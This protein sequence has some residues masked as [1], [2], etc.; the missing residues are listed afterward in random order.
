MLLKC[1]RRLLTPRVRAKVCLVAAGEQLGHV[2]EVAQPIVDRRRGE[3]EERLRPHRVV[4]QVEEPVVAR[5]LGI[6]HHRR[7]AARI[8]EVM[9][10][11]DHHDVGKLGDAPETLREIALAAE[12]GVAEDRE[13]AEVRA[14][15]DCRRCAAAIRADVAPTP[16]SL[17]AFGANSTTRFPS[18]RT[19]RSISIRP[20]KVLPRPTPSQ[21]NAPPCW[22]AIFISA[23]Y[24]SFW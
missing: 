5:R 8:A 9:R 2:P 7:R 12:V 1:A 24:A 6:V 17:V 22:R 10:L 20:T 14:A 13:V 21:R 3:H 18:C 23:Q 11:V 4:E 19:R 15:A 16:P